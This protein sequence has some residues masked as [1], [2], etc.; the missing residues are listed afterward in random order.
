METKN[1]YLYKGYCIVYEGSGQYK[2]S[3]L[4]LRFNSVRLAKDLI[5]TLEDKEESE[6]NE[7]YEE[8]A[9]LQ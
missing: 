3:G 6:D 8:S 9:Y 1:E 5:D 4:S 7:L 2:I